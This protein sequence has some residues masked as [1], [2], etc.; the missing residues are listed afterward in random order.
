L[1]PEASSQMDL[2]EIRQLADL[3]AAHDLSE[4]FVRDGER[5]ILIRRGPPA[6]PV[7]AAP[8]VAPAHAAHGGH[9]GMAVRP[10]P[11][12]APAAPGGANGTYIRSPMVG[13]FYAAKEPGK[14]ELVTVGSRVE[15]ETVVCVIDAMKV[16]NDIKAD[17]S[18]T[19][20]AVL[21]HNAQPVEFGQPL[22]R[23][24]PR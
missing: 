1:T 22:F 15:P 4:I 13:T 19:I 2:D 21:V 8:T 5:R 10:E 7:R 18:G 24:S 3:L 14:P 6:G 23:V 11:A 16:F 20:E 9:A 12:A 17:L